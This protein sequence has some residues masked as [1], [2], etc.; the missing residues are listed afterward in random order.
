MTDP[1]AAVGS[2]RRGQPKPLWSRNL[3]THLL[4]RGA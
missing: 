2:E 3:Y 4:A 1:H